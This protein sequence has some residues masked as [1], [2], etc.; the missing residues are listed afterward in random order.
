LVGK[1]AP[2]LYATLGHGARGMTTAPL[3]GE[4]LAAMICDEPL[5]L[6]GDWVERLNPMRM[7]HDGTEFAAKGSGS[8]PTPG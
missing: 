1:L 4:F 3:C 6:G 2:G 7:S 5:P 8:R